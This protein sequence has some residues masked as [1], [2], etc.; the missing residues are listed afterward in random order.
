[1][2]EQLPYSVGDTVIFCGDYER[3]P[4]IKSNW[5]YG[6]VVDLK[7]YYHAGQE[8]VNVIVQLPEDPAVQSERARWEVQPSTIN[9]RCADPKVARLAVMS[10]RAMRHGRVTAV[11]SLDMAY[12]NGVNEL[13]RSLAASS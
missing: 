13:F 1:M 10:L 4:E 7:T 9:M 12:T 11:A 5:H 6:R 2:A 3:D 8:V